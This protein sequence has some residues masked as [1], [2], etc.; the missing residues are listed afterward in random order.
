M[1]IDGAPVLKPVPGDIAVQARHQHA[2]ADPAGRLRA[3]SYFIHVYDGWLMSSS[4]TGPWEKPFLPPGGADA[5]AQSLAEDRRRRP[6]RRRP[7]GQ[8]EAVAR[9]R[10]AGDL[11]EPGADGADRLQGPARFRADRRHAAPVGVEHVERRADQHR[12]QQLL[13]A[14]RGPLVHRRARS[15]GRGRSSRATRCRRT[16]RAFRRTRSRAPCCPRSP[17]RRRRRKR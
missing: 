12:E 6:P 5:I 14:A 13:R 10:R 3:D 16:S 2:R 11:H 4:L 7:Q 9:E 1:P 15:T 8:S 17:A